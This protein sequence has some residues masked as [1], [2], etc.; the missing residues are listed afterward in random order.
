MLLGVLLERLAS[1]RRR[2]FDVYV[3]RLS[4]WGKVEVLYQGGEYFVVSIYQQ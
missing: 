2:V 1:K 4:W 3:D